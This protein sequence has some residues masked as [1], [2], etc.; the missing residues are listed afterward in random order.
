MSIKFD[1]QESKILKGVFL[2]TPNKFK[3]LRGEIW[4]AF[5]SEN[6][7]GLLPEGLCFKHDKFIT[8]KKDVI[9]GIHGDSKTYKLATCLYGEVLQ[10]VVDCNPSSP[11][12]LKHEKFVISPQNQLIVLV[13]KGFGN[14]H[15]VR[16]EE[17][18]YYY[19]CAYEGAYMDADAQFTYAWN[20]E[21]IG[22]EWGID[23]PI[24]SERDTLATKGK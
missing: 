20:D 17:A 19:K 1:I 12:Y 24:L 8:S 23:T 14:A 18:V 3:D 11:T 16:S 21:R 9:R 2:I 10:V 13:P 4:T 15:L 6:I 7:D 5:T 22:V